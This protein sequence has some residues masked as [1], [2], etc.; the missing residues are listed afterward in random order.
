MLESAVSDL[1]SSL[2]GRPPSEDHALLST[3]LKLVAPP[4]EVGISLD[5]SDFHLQAEPDDHR[6]ICDNECIWLKICKQEE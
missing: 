6:L 4:L 2:G 1:D 5:L 3:A